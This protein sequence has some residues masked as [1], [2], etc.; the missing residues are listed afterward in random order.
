MHLM[1]YCIY[2]V[3]TILLYHI[4]VVTLSLLTS[5]FYLNHGLLFPHLSLMLTQ[6]RGFLNIVV[7]LHGNIVIFQVLVW[8]GTINLRTRRSSMLDF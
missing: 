4:L 6:G 7:D 2:L 8:T 1:T 3:V 5:I